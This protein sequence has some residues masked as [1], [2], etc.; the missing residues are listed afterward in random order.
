MR[1]SG[2]VLSMF[3]RKIT[4]SSRRFR[5]RRSEPWP[6]GR[7]ISSPS[8]VSKG[9]V[10]R[11]DGDGV[12]SPDPGWRCRPRRPYPDGIRNHGSPATEALRTAVSCSRETVKW[13]RETFP[14]IPGVEGRLDKVLLEGGPAP[15]RIGVEFQKRLGKESVIQTLLR[16]DETQDGRLRLFRIR[17]SISRPFAAITARRSGKKGIS[18]QIRRKKA[19]LSTSSAKPPASRPRYHSRN[20]RLAAP[21]A[22]TNFMSRRV[23]RASS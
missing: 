21:D 4:S 2:T 8:L 18:L 6:P 11:I 16:Q 3:F 10:F 19:S 1:R 13:R 15:F 12:R 14:R 7:K 17:S 20:I 9:A 5:F 22:G 23:R